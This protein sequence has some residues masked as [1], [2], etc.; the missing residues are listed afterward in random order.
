MVSSKITRRLKEAFPKAFITC[1]LEFIAD[2]DVNSYFILED[3]RDEED[4]MAKCLE[5]LSRD[6]CS[7][8]HYGSPK[9][10]QQCRRYHR[11]GINRFCGTAFDEEDIEAI[12]TRLG[13]KCNHAMTLDF[14][15]SGFDMR[16][17]FPEFGVGDECDYPV[18][19][20]TS[21]SHAIVEI[22]RISKSHMGKAEIKVL[23]VINDSDSD[24]HLTVSHETGKTMVV[25]LKYCNKRIREEK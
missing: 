7:G 15:R 4:V 9:K 11:I 24:N 8:A 12:Y 13:N 17:L 23:E 1:N 6:A 5:W 20:P 18:G 16:V 22:V 25:R 19:H 2:P 14:I 10:N 21:R 3:C